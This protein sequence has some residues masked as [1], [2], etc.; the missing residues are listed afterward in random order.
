MRYRY[1]GEN[2]VYIPYIG[3][4]MPGDTKEVETVINHPDFEEVR[5]TEDKS[6]VKKT[7]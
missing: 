2:S 4:F 1:N 6:K 7:K 3:A 5:E